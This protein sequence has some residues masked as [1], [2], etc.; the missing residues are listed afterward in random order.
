[1]NHL[2]TL[3]DSMLDNTIDADALTELAALIR[4]DEISRA[5][6]DAALE[7]H[8]TIDV[9]LSALMGV[10][11]HTELQVQP[12]PAAKSMPRV[13]TVAFGIAKFAAVLLLVAAAWIAGGY[14]TQQS[15]PQSG[16]ALA[17]NEE[18]SANTALVAYMQA[19]MAEGRVIRELTPVTLEMQPTEFGV[20][21]T[22]VRNILE[23]ALIE[24][25]Y[26]LSQDEHGRFVGIRSEVPVASGQSL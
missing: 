17:L 26:R 12:S 23:R 14:V 24:D 20:E 6:F 18:M 15:A 16:A 19:G 5:R 13:R 11:Q 21:V 7:A 4:R 22:Y 10:A 8:R 9:G 3:I 1:M 2:D 25:V